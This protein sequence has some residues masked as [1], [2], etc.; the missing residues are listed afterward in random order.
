[1]SRYENI[2]RIIYKKVEEWKPDSI[3]ELGFG[4]G[5][6]AIAAAYGL[7]KFNPKGKINTYD[8]LKEVPVFLEGNKAESRI[9]ER[10]LNNYINLT[11]GDVFTEWVN[12][13]FNFNLLLID[14]NNT[15][16][17][18]HKIVIVNS[19]I[20]NKVKEGAKVL[21]EGGDPNHP[22]INQNSLNSFNDK[23]GKQIFSFVHL[24]GS[25]RT[26]ISELKIL[27]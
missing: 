27:V 10:N 20:Y 21:I 8:S 24:G 3:V 12:K 15:W 23:N 19:F 16:D 6:L 4:S 25:G 26:S 14:I 5:A 11:V 18:I 7:E 2:E 1:M 9:K 22:R 13:P 17:I